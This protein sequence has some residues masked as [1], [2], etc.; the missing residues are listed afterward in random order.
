MDLKEEES[1]RFGQKSSLFLKELGR[2]LERAVVLSGENRCQ[3]AR[4]LGGVGNGKCWQEPIK[5]LARATP[6]K[7]W[8]I[9]S[10]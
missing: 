5:A 4:A 9:V 7:F 1:L 10:L 8:G 6:L 3:A 2:K